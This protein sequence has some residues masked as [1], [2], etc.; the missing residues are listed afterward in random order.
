MRWKKIDS[1]VCS[2]ARSLAIFGDRWTLLIIRDAFK[3]IRRFSDFQSSLGISKHRLSDRL[4]RLVDA[5]ILEK[6]MYDEKRS[7]YEYR[8]TEKGID[9]YPVL[10]SV[11]N[12]GDKW[13]SDENGSPFVFR[14]KSCGELTKPKLMC[15]ICDE[16]INAR[17]IV[18]ELG[19]G[20][21][22]SLNDD[23]AASA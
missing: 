17:D 21:L 4:N 3:K 6:K 22:N 16:E 9:L 23:G 11:V 2:I 15:N 14:H 19:P 1:Q 5:G 10:M 7:R 12:W 20:S 13:A 18:P 8:L